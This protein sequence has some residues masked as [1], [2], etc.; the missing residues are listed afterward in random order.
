MR[1]KWTWAAAVIALAGCDDTK[2]IPAAEKAPGA[3]SIIEAG[4]PE[5]DTGWWPSLTF[6][7]EDRA[8][9]SYC[10]AFHGDL[11]YATQH[12]GSWKTVTVIKQL[13]I[14]REEALKI[15]EQ[16]IGRANE[17]DQR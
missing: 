10:D 17:E 3:I 2:P 16:M 1:P 7:R 11:K 6:D 12:N 4:G 15:F 14:D 13:G 8:H 5:G 9:L